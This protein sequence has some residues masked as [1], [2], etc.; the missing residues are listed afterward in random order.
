MGPVARIVGLGAAALLICIGPA[1]TQSPPP[2]QVTTDTPEYCVHLRDRV[3]EMIREAEV[4]PP[5][6]VAFLS[7][8][9]QRMCDHGQTR[10][11]IQ[12]LRRALVMM[13]HWSA[14]P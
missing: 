3:R 2:Q 6:E 9:G 13:M 14:G 12:R 7:S 1:A 5:G 4:P 11:G 10:G 8:E